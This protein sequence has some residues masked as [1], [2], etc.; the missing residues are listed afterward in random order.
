MRG[1]GRHYELDVTCEGSPDPQ[2][3][4]LVNIK[5]IDTAVRSRVTPS[6]AEACARTPHAEPATMLEAMLS[7]LRDA[8]PTRVKAVRWRLSPYYSV[9]MSDDVRDRYVI[10]QQFDFAAAHRLHVDALSD[11]ENR[12]IFGRCNNPTS[13]G[14]NYR[15]EPAVEASLRNGSPAMTLETLEQLTMRTLI[16]R[17]DHKNLSTDLPEFSPPGGVNPS[18][19][20]I[21]RVMY[22]LLAPQIASHTNGAARLKALTVWETDRTSCTFEAPTSEGQ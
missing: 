13:H 15:V 10:R 9:E 19:E 14:H 3:G 16:D 7:T 20:N 18:V 12:R 22:E 4:Y 6:L 2:T 5:E 11:E 21:A 1:L 8:L 17:F